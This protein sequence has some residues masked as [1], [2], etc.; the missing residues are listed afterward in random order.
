VEVKLFLCYSE[1]LNLTAKRTVKSEKMGVLF[2]ISCLLV[3]FCAKYFQERSKR[4]K[5][6]VAGSWIT[7]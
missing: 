6:P 2:L 5:N 3:T 7:L 4:T 1:K